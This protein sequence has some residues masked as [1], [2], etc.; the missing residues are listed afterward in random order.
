MR[1]VT[2]NP[3]A[4]A[5]FLSMTQAVE[6][7]SKSPKSLIAQIAATQKVE[8]S[9]FSSAAMIAMTDSRG[10]VCQA[11][12]PRNG[13][14]I[15]FTVS[16]VGGDKLGEINID[17]STPIDSINSDDSFPQFRGILNAILEG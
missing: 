4:Y 8:F 3:D 16:L 9:R 17:P 6:K 11:Q 14:R 12:R 7:A 5:L 13:S 10:T 15:I 1:I 2:V